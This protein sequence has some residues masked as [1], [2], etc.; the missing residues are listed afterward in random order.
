MSLSPA[1]KALT[2][3]EPLNLNAPF[4]IRRLPGQTSMKVY[5]EASLTNN[6]LI[7]GDIRISQWQSENI[8]LLRVDNKPTS[9]DDYC[10]AVRNAA[11]RSAKRNG[12]TVIARTICGTFKKNFA[13]LEMA[14]KYFKAFPT[15][16]CFMFYHPRTGYWMSAS[17]ELLAEFDG[18]NGATRALAGTRKANENTAWDR[19][20]MD[21]HEMVVRDIRQR[22]RDL[23]S[24][25][26]CIAKDS[27]NLRYG[28][29]E[30]LCTPMEIAYLGDNEADISS[31]IT[32]LNP[33]PAVGGYPRSEALSDIADIEPIQRKFY[34]GVISD[35]SLAYIILRCVHFDH[36]HWC[37]YTG[38]GI[39]GR[40]TV[41]DEWTE[42]EA[43][44]KPLI[45]LLSSF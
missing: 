13:P 21:E 7:F 39:T 6:E 3:M 40:S 27:L 16:F 18:N 25:W 37:V 33:T 10:A 29:I 12:K 28:N 45:N 41:E 23:G 19:K 17:P 38:S 22:I 24:D 4:L 20:N 36:R 9:F 35:K 42:T 44:A 2:Y 1:A 15:M 34:G 43:K 30:H 32:A 8:G 5:T 14:R 11:Q 26:T 31:V